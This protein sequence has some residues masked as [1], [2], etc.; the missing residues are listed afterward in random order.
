MCRYVYI[1]IYICTCNIYIY[2]M[3]IYI[4]TYI[5]IVYIT[6]IYI[7]QLL[8]PEES[9]HL[10]I[11][12][13]PDAGD[14]NTYIYIYIYICICIYCL[15]CLC[16]TYIHTYIHNILYIVPGSNRIILDSSL[17]YYILYRVVLCC[18]RSH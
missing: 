7:Y 14:R 6:Y 10:L 16:H 15:L 9:S 4:H 2:D 13:T 3:Y 5:H 1:Y 8:Y 17:L 12:D 11:K 18:V